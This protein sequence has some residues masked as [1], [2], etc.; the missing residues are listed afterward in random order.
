MNNIYLYS[1]NE[2]SEGAK[3][4]ALGLN[5]PRIKHNHSKFKGGKD[6]I[7]I[8]WGS[9]ELLEEIHKCNVIN[10]PGI[11]GVVTNKLNFLKLCYNSGVRVPE[12]TENETRAKDWIRRGH[13]V[14]CRRILN[15]S[16]GAGIVYAETINELIDAPLYTKYVS[17]KD[18]YRIHCH[19]SAGD[20]WGT[21]EASVFFIQRKYRNPETIDPNWVIRNLEGGF[22]YEN[23]NVK[24]PD[25]VIEQAYNA[26]IVS[27]LHFGAV[28]VIWNEKR[29]KAYVL[30]INTA[31]GIEGR[32]LQ[33]YI[34]IFKE[35][36]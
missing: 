30:E 22:L 17:K 25:D 16:G 35:M 8:N 13:A 20:D 14:M 4:L 5:I 3:Q 33:E 15:G 10:S 6:K 26:F 2:K 34:K 29:N 36:I 12:L 27:N 11:I 23:K 31:P 18:E 7:V 9:S 19:R 21:S 1:H 24:P 32:T 28:D